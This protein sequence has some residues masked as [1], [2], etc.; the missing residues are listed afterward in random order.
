MKKESATSDQGAYIRRRSLA[1]TF[2]PDVR[3]IWQTEAKPIPV[4]IFLL[5]DE[6]RHGQWGNEPQ[7]GNALQGSMLLLHGKH[8]SKR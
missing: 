7:S 5:F 2:S 8:M 6:L 1:K 4:D 3:Y